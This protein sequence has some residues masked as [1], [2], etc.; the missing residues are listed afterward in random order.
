LYRSIKQLL[1]AGLIEESDQRPDPALDDE[2][3]H[4]Y[5]LTEFGR[6]VAVAEAR[7]LEEALAIARTRRGLSGL[8]PAPSLEGTS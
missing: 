7:R 6:H 8:F 1:E 5:R 4:Y 2:R 3:R